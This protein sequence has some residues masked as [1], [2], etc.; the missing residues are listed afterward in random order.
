[1]AIVRERRERKDGDTLTDTGPLT[2]PKGTRTLSLREL[3]VRTRT[4][5]SSPRP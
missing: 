2:A 5:T 3:P 4:V 1:M